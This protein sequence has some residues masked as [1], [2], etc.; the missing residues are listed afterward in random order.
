MVLKSPEICLLRLSGNP[1]DK[2]LD[3]TLFNEMP[4]C[5]TVTNSYITDCIT[6]TVFVMTLGV[7]KWFTKFE[8]LRKMC[9]FHTQH[10]SC[11]GFVSL[12]ELDVMI[13]IHSLVDHSLRVS[14]TPDDIPCTLSLGVSVLCNLHHCLMTSIHCLLGF[15]NDPK[16][17][18]KVTCQMSNL[19]TNS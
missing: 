7:V 18:L 12:H 14:V 9:I 3:F 8:N 2:C 16:T 11:F 17:A 5:F 10:K 13:P 19:Y 15:T 4:C 6:S 1:V